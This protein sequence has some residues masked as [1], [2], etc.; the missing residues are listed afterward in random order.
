LIGF[1]SNIDTV[2]ISG[3]IGGETLTIVSGTDGGVT[4]GTVML[5]KATGLTG[6]QTVSLSWTNAGDVGAGAI[7][8]TGVDQATPFNNGSFVA[9]TGSLSITST[10]GDLTSSITTGTASITTNQTSKWS[11]SIG[12]IF[13]GGDIGPGT[14][15]TTH[16]WTSTFSMFMSGANFKQVA[17]GVTCTNFITLMGAGCQ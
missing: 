14:G 7:S 13:T 4:T 9:S 11:Q 6:A 3:T 8:A 17:A 1:G 5:G 16:T 15:T 2:G 10:S 12:A